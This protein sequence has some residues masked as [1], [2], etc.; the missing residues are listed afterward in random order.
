MNAVKEEIFA[1]A[2]FRSRQQVM[3]FEQELRKAGISSAIV[4]TPRAVSLG[5]GLSVRFAEKDAHAAAALCRRMGPG[6][7][8]GFYQVS[9]SA[10]GEAKVRPLGVQCRPQG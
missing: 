10:S 8:I 3:A 1:I 5:C 7:L 4:T 9:R 2:A 6:N